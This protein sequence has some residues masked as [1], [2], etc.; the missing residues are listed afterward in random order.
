MCW[1][2]TA[3][4]AASA[5]LVFSLLVFG[6]IPIWKR[7]KRKAPI[8]RI[9]VLKDKAIE[10]QNGNN[11]NN[12]TEDELNN[13]K[14]EVENLKQELLDEISKIS[15][16]I[17]KQYKKFGAVDISMF[18]KIADGEQQMYLGYIRRCWELAD[19]IIDKY[20]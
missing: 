18:R 3:A 12:L 14:R 4:I 20:L 11:R 7:F 10:I 8:S 15:K 16:P 6:V 2:I 13:F 19:K 1:E 9:H 5:T 17:S